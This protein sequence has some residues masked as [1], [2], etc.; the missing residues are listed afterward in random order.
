[1]SWIR[2]KTERGTVQYICPYCYDYH[3]FR[4]D[5]GESAFGENFI[6]CRR[7]GARNGAGTVPT[8]ALSIELQY[9]PNCGAKM[10]DREE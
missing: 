4:E 8:I 1:M 7:C 9:Y 3:E 2:R 6:F 10:E 5:F